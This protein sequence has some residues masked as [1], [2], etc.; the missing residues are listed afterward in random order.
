MIKLRE[1]STVGL[2]LSA[3][4]LASTAK[5]ATWTEINNPSTSG[6]TVGSNSVTYGPVA[7]NEV[8]VYDGSSPLGAQ[9][10][11]AIQSLV[12]TQFGL[13]TSGAGSLVLA[14]RKRD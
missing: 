5:A 3:L 2:M 10:P 11:T 6:F 7:A 12:T 14:S 1:I 8:W 13:P 4:L 9:S